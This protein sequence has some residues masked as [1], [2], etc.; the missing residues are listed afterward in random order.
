MNTDFKIS[1]SIFPVPEVIY[2]GISEQGIEHDYILPDYYPDIFRLVKCDAVP[3]IISYSVNDGRLTYEL[4]VDV[5][6]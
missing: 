5:N 6:F 4:S 1:K 3:E 2:E